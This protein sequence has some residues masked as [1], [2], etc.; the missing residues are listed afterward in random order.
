MNTPIHHD[1]DDLRHAE[2]VL[3]VLDADART[4]VELEIRNDPQAAIDIQWWQQRLTPLSEDI[5]ANAPP[6]YI[7]ARIEDALG[8]QATIAVATPR[9]AP[10]R[11]LWNSLALWRLLGIGASVIAAA[12]LVLA[13]VVT[14][15]PSSAPVTTSASYMVARIQQNNGVA[16]W[17]ATMD[18][19]HARMVVVPATPTAVAG[20]R[21]TELWLIPPGQK[22]VSLGLI[23]EDHAT[24]VALSPA[25][26]AQ[27]GPNALLAVSVEPRGGSPSGQPTGPVVAKGSIGAVTA[28][29]T[30]VG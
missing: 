25:L 24:T 23:A 13:I 18:I 20:D 14:R 2:Y 22:P 3:G 15:P 27:L 9:P 29:S 19:K 5:A 1:H 26:L 30:P 28:P 17:T 4:A 10:R 21:S 8:Q 11:G 7:W 16:G 12:C 6:H